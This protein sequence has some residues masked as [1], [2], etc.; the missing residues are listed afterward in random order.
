MIQPPKGIGNTWSPLTGVALAFSTASLLGGCVA[1]VRVASPPAVYEAPAPAYGEPADVELRATDAPPPLPEY[2]QPPCP[3]DGYLWTPGYWAYG[4]GGYFWVPGTWV[5]PP[6]RRRAVDPRLLGLRGRRVCIPHRVLGSP[7]RILRRRELRPWLW[8]HGL[9]GRPWSGNS[10]AYN[11]TV[12]NVNVTH[13]HN[14]YNETVINNVT[15]NRVS[16]NGGSGGLSAAPTSQDRAASREQHAAPTPLQREH[17]VEAV[18]N[19]A[20]AVRANG[21]HPPI[22]A[23]PRPA[24]FNA[25]GVVGA[26]GSSTPAAAE[27]RR[28]RDGGR[29]PGGRAAIQQWR[30]W[31]GSAGGRPAKLDARAAERAGNRAQ[32][33]AWTRRARNVTRR[34]CLARADRERQ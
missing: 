12:N 1:Q 26:R 11:R 31:C 3:D 28:A 7:C 16:Y 10:F 2:E 5:Q 33:H 23:T 9:C 27:L 4:G 34:E 18:R 29:G 22:A 30:E 17:V 20:L 8:R 32:W 15:V 25:P 14:T 6:P 21:G 13:V 19:P 24:A